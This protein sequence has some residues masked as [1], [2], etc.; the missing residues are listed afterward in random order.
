MLQNLHFKRC[1]LDYDFLH[2][3]PVLTAQLAA[4]CC[5]LIYPFHAT[6]L[7]IPLENLKKPELF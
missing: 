6:G 2:I 7:S 3:N 5:Y 4:G 1:N